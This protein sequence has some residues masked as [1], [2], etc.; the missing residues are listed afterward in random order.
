MEWGPAGSVKSVY[1]KT[2]ELLEWDWGV[3]SKCNANSRYSFRRTRGNM[4]A[5]R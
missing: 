1:C 4:R 3:L 5:V 2:A